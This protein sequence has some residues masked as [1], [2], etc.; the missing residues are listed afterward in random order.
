MSES[1]SLDAGET[2]SAAGLATPAL[3]SKNSDRIAEGVEGWS[4]APFLVIVDQGEA[5]EVHVAVQPT[6]R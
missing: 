3:V 2:L 4:S 1:A 5:P 6:G